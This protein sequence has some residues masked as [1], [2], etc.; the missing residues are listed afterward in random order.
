MRTAGLCLAQPLAD[1]LLM[2][3]YNVLRHA[4]TQPVSCVTW[5]SY[6]PSQYS[7]V[8]PSY[9]LATAV[10][11]SAQDQSATEQMLS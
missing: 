2:F 5:F 6:L 11:C 8:L 9:I 1:D 4:P 3:Y 10:R 7:T